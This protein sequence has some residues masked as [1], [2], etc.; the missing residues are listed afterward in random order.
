MKDDVTS[1]AILKVKWFGKLTSFIPENSNTWGILVK[2]GIHD[3][4]KESSMLIP[5]LW[6]AKPY[7][8]PVS[9]GNALNNMALAIQK[10][11][12]QS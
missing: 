4:L 1:T 6:D 2:A 10:N 8:A 12:V 3:F 7:L 9:H 5:F 11:T